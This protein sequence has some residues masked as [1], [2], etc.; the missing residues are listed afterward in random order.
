M[1]VSNNESNDSAKIK[2]LL[3]IIKKRERYIYSLE[4]KIYDEKKKLKDIKEKLSVTCK[5]NWVP[6]RSYNNYDHTPYYCTI[7]G[8]DN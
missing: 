1:D 6:D 4:N 5:H 7:C 2:N 3:D 8:L